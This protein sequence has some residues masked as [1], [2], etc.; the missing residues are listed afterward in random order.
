MVGMLRRFRFSTL[1]SKKPRARAV[2]GT[3]RVMLGVVA[4]V[5]LHRAHAIGQARQHGEQRRQFGVGALGHGAVARQHVFRAGKQELRVGVDEIIELGARAL[6]ARAL[7]H[8]IHFHV[9]A[10]HLA[11]AQFMDLLRAHG[12]G[13]LLGDHGL[14]EGGAA[15]QAGGIELL[16]R[17]R[18]VFV[19]HERLESGKRRHHG[20]GNGLAARFREA[21]LVV[22]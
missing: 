13:G 14:V 9:D 7:H 18:Q 16:A 22:R 19:R 5:G 8:L 11:Q 12:G 20:L 17:R 4:L 2:A 3:A 6:E 10:R 15:R 1:A 21:A